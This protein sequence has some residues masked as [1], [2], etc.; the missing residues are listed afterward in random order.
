M[1]TTPPPRPARQPI[2]CWH[3]G[4]RIQTGEPVQRS[5]HGWL[6]HPECVQQYTDPD[7][8]PDPDPPDEEH[9]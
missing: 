8:D 1:T 5:T 6:G 9:P 7:P 2:T 4:D 3:C